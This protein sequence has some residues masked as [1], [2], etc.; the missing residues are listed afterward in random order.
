MRPRRRRIPRSSRASAR[1]TLA[2][3][4]YDFVVTLGVSLDS[5]FAIDGHSSSSSS[6]TAFAPGTVGGDGI[7]GD[8][9]IGVFASPAVG[10]EAGDDSG[11]VLVDCG[12]LTSTGAVPGCVG[13]F[14]RSAIGTA[15]GIT[16]AGAAGLAGIGTGDDVMRFAR[17]GSSTLPSEDLMSAFVS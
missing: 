3:V 6:S 17:R 15:S 5:L 2:R 11:D 7:E 8:D 1:D 4:R 9:D 13:S 10:V 16:A 14:V 12:R